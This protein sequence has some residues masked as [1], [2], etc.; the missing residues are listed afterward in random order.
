ML[1]LLGHMSR[2]ILEPYRMAAKREGAPA[3]IQLI[4]RQPTSN[5]L[6]TKSPTNESVSV[7]PVISRLLI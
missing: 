2:A 5:G 1:A 7:D 4:T 3:R 6:P